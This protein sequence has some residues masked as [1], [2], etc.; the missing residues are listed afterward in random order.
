M[1]QAHVWEST[2][3]PCL[4]FGENWPVGTFAFVDTLAELILGLK[5]FVL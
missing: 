2:D 4:D 5:H 3:Q 1:S